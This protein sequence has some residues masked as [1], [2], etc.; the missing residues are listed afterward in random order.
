MA[1]PA[2]DSTPLPPAHHGWS[3]ER[4]EQVVGNLLRTGVVLSAAVVLLGGVIYLWRHAREPVTDYSQFS[5]ERA[6]VRHVLDIVDRA[7][8][9]SGRGLVELGLLLLIATPIAR[10]VFSAAA[11]AGQRDHTYVAITLLV[12]GVLLFSLFSGYVH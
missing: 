5:A 3:D 12:L 1:A 11:F 8:H 7:R 4:V 6:Q 2:G 9:L 10:V